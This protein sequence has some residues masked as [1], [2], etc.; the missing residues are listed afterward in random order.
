MSQSLITHHNHFPSICSSCFP[1]IEPELTH[2]NC[3]CYLLSQNDH[4]FSK[5]SKII[6]RNLHFQYSKFHYLNLIPIL[7]YSSLTTSYA[8]YVSSLSVRFSSVVLS[9]ELI[10]HILDVLEHYE[11]YRLCLILCN[12]YEMSQRIGRYISAISTN[13]SNLKHF[14]EQLSH[15]SGKNGDAVV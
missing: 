3:K 9:E 5:L 4:L 15:I 1:L 6:L 14:F 2:Q 11:L 13:Y 8:S 10:L 7:F 12:R